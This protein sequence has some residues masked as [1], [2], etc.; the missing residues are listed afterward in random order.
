MVP[1]ESPRGGTV[2]Y[3]SFSW[4]GDGLTPFCSV[5]LGY[6]PPSSNYEDLE[7]F[8]KKFPIYKY[9]LYFASTASCAE[10]ERNVRTTFYLNG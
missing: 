1:G 6:F 7:V 4:V 8:V 5:S 9:Q 3:C 2:S 10:L